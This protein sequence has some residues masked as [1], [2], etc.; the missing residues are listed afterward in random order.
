MGFIDQKHVKTVLGYFNIDIDDPNVR[1]AIN[2]FIPAQNLKNF[3]DPY[4][5]QIHKVNQ[6]FYFD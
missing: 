2:L 6:V 1:K 4:V 3:E 5:I